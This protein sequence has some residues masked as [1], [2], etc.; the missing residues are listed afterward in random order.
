MRSHGRTRRAKVRKRPIDAEVKADVRAADQRQAGGDRL[1][2]QHADR[3]EYGPRRARYSGGG[4][5]VV[6]NDLHYG[7]SLHNYE[8]VKRP[9]WTSA[10]SSI[11]IIRWTC[12]TSRKWWIAKPSS[13]PS[14]SSPTSTATCTRSQN[15]RPGS[16][17]R[18]LFVRGCDPGCRSGSD[19]RQ[20]D[21]HRF[22]GVLGIQVADGRP[23]RLLVCPRRS[24]GHGSESE[25]VRRPQHSATGASRY[26]ISTVSHLG[27]VCQHQALQYIHSLA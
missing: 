15:Q 13:S 25:A 26:E 18:R 10:S 16:R 23:I 6:T 4:G 7:G 24:A 20:S 2:A 12:A 1:H 11:A 21:G 8:T 22:P 9:V 5:N 17:A 14:R 3:R 27:C 19:R